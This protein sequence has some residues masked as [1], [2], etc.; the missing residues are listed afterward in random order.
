MQLNIATINQYKDFLENPQKYECNYKPIK[1]CFAPSKYVT[2]Q[3]KLYELYVAHIDKPLPKVV[4]YII[5]QELYDEYRGKAPYDEKTKKGG[6]LGYYLRVDVPPSVGIHFVLVS[7]PGMLFEV[8]GYNERHEAVQ[9]KVTANGSSFA[10][11]ISFV[12][13]VNGV[14]IG[15]YKIIIQ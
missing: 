15:E 8:T 3:D 10:D 7:Q 2:P 4:F 9:T 6:E 14:S 5:M 11:E 1:E 13:F 12:D